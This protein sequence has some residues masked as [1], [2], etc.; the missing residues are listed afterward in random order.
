MPMSTSLI[1][2]AHLGHIL[3][4]GGT[5]EAR[6]LTGILKVVLPRSRLTVSLAGRTRTPAPHAAPLCTGGF[7]GPEGLAHWI[8]EQNVTLLI[9]A[10]HPFAARMPGHAALAADMVGIPAIQLQRPAWRPELGDKWLTCATIEEAP[11][12]LGAHSQNVFLPIGRQSILPFCSAPQHH[13]VI[14]SIEPLSMPHRLPRLTSIQARGPYS[15]EDEYALMAQMGITYMVC[16]NSGA[17]SMIAKLSA[18]RAL[19]IPVIMV[20]RPSLGVRL[21]TFPSE[22]ALVDGLIGG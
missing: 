18:A 6:R 17:P 5:A 2:H 19:S 7:G 13:Y 21:T 4:L 9:V 15:H 11:T 14:R 22:A 16:K 10:T 1:R 3:I 12:L 20:E 8:R